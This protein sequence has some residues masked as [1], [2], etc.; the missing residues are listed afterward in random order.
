MRFV[1]QELRAGI[2]APRSAIPEV[3]G[4]CELLPDQHRGYVTNLFREHDPSARK[5]ELVL[6]PLARTD[7]CSNSQSISE[8][9][10]LRESYQRFLSDLTTH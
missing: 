6:D 1:F 2:G 3:D 7:W 10:S 9:A 5:R 4:S 8:E